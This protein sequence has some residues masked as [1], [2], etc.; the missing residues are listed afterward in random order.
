MNKKIS[1]IILAL[2]VCML[3]VLAA[4]IEPLADRVNYWDSEQHTVT[5]TNNC[6]VSAQVNITMSGSFVYDS[7]TCSNSGSIITCDIASGS[8]KTYTVNSSSSDSEYDVTTFT[9]VT[10]NSCTVST[11]SFIKIKNYEI[12]HTLVEYGRGRGNYFYDT[13]GGGDYAGSG[14]TGIG[15]PYLPNGTMFELNFLHKVNNVKQYF[16]DLSATAY[17]A[18]FSCVYTNDTVVRTHLITDVVTNSTGTYLDYLIPKIEGS[19]ER[20]GYVGMD[21]DAGDHDFGQSFTINC[22]DITYYMPIAGGNFLVEEDSFTF[23]IRNR[24]PFVASASSTAIIGNGTQEVI[25]TYNIT[26][27]ELYTLDDVIIEIQAPPYAQFIGIRGELWGYAQD[28]YRIE[29]AQLLP[30]ESEVIRLVARFDT[31]NAPDMSTIDLTNG[32][33]T[34]YT[35]CWELNAYNP[36]EYTQILTGIGSETVNMSIPSNII[37]VITRIVQI[38]NITTIINTTI[39]QID[40]TITNINSIVN[41]INT[42]TQDTNIIVTEINNTANTILNNTNIIITNTNII[43]NDTS[44]IIDLL[45]CNGT[46]DSPICDKLKLLNNSIYELLNF[47]LILNHTANNIN[48]TVIQNI[49]TTGANVTINA[50]YSDLINRLREVKTYINCTNVSSQ[51]NTSICNKLENIEDTTVILNNSVISILNITTNF[52]NTFFGNFT[53]QQIFDAINNITVDTT[54]VRD[55]LEELREFDEE[56]VF[57]ITDSFGLQQTA[58]DDFSRGDV[59]SAADKLVQSNNRLRKTID[60]IAVEQNK[61]TQQPQLE[62]EKKGSNVSLIALIAA[63]MAVVVMYMYA[64][65]PPKGGKQQTGIVKLIPLILFGL[66]CVSF[67]SAGFG[68]SGTITQEAEALNFGDTFKNQTVNIYYNCLGFRYFNVS[69]PGGFSVTNTDSPCGLINSTLISCGFTDVGDI[70]GGYTLQA[71]GSFSDYSILNFPTSLSNTT[72]CSVTNNITFLKVPDEEV[73]YTLVEYGRGRGNYFYSTVGGSAGSGHTGTGCPYV[74]NATMFELNFLH[75]I[76]NIKQYYDDADAL[77]TNVTFTCSYPDN[78]IVRS[79]LGTSIQNNPT[80]TTITYNIDEIKGD[81]ERMGYV[82]MQ[83]DSSESYIGQNLTISCYDISYYLETQD[84]FITVYP[85][86]TTFNLQ[87]RDS[88]PFTST[89]T[90]LSTIGNGT[91]E[92]IIRYN[93]TNTE[94]YTVDDVVIE[95]EAPS[96]AEF[97]GIRGELWGYA[98]DQYRIEK[99]SLAPG[100]SEIIDLVA[101]FDTTNAPDI[102]STYLSNLIKFKYITCWDLNAYNPGETVQR[103]YGVGNGTVNMGIPSEVIDIREE[104]EEIFN[105]LT[106]INTTTININNTVNTIESLVTVINSTTID[107]NLIVQ[108]INNTIV[109]ILN[110]TNTIITNTNTIIADTSTIKDLLNCNGTIDTPICDDLDIMNSTV[111]DIT[112]IIIDINQTLSDITVN[113]TINLAGQNLTVNITPDLTNITLIIDDI[114]SELNCT[115]VTGMPETDICIRLLRIENNTISINNTIEEINNLV[116]YFNTTTFGNVTLTDIYNAIQNTTVDTTELLTIIRR[117][118]EFDEELVFLVTDS[119][120][121]QQAAATE[122]N[123]GNVG[124]ATSKLRDANDRL[125]EAAV[126]LMELQNEETAETTVSEK[127]EKGSNLIVTLLVVIMCLVVIVYL[128]AKPPKGR[129]KQKM[130]NEIK[131]MEEPDDMEPPKP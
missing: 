63:L 102:T 127:E 78:T 5:V 10:N 14:H 9:A 101:R 8:S 125:N 121:L 62:T 100:E 73:F 46:N 99:I 3:N 70:I 89:A 18:S 51:P 90:T 106:I 119:F 22:T 130:V 104:I 58:K 98:Q 45:N 24:Y 115:N 128:V 103:T 111:T 126:R 4:D 124:E 87:V 1:L 79:H 34:K 28:Q 69:L 129:Q 96:Y 112:D 76:F 13:Y 12:F 47:T 71:T 88:T 57:L 33:K 82:G 94:I 64:K 72:D 68:P 108:Q 66:L 55:A 27:N 61:L 114:M 75:K 48:I 36:N 40:T 50:D 113:V 83:F 92:V 116:L 43:M 110:N 53:F 32:I 118:R 2:M 60:L 52:N 81:W 65:N 84:G 42:T 37:S 117:M 54:D 74:P 120:G 38:N 25:I 41:V 6:D 77:A 44:D 30:G 21:Y 17:N 86:G 122:L 131:N 11:T 29:K 23:N 59:V 85:T 39:S 105:T 91:Q 80:N 97:V 67:A 93:I 15:C 16:G 123:K 26:N 19:W 56:I 109:T 95:I 35:T 7:G 107:T 31:T 20:M 49:N